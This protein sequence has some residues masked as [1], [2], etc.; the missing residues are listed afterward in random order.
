MAT[1]RPYLSKSGPEMSAIFE[2]S[3]SDAKELKRLLRE[4][5][6]R[7]TPSAMALRR[8]VD[9]ALLLLET[10]STSSRAQAPTNQNVECRNCTTHLRVPIKEDSA[11]YVCP[12]CKSEFEVQYQFGV[13]QVTWVE[14]SLPP[15]RDEV[16]MSESLARTILGVDTSA[17][18]A[19]IK[20]AW[21][22]AS[23][24]YHPD[25][26]QRLPD[27]LKEAAARE[28]QRINTAYQYLERTTAD[29]F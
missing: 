6:H 9:A 23:Q 18:F 14:K 16:D 1:N 2:A 25:K 4:L 20:A 28:M 7:T 12:S 11:V 5:N 10:G 8:K 27:R 29:D 13:M 24:Q 19:V 15:Q 26:H 3:R 21:R 22:K 17:S